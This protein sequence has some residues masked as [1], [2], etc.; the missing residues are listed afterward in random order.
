[1]RS[2]ISQTITLPA[3][4]QELFEMYLDSARHQE[5]TGAPVTIA[6][7]PG[8]EFR[9]FDGVLSGTILVVSSPDLI[10]QSW[11]STAFKADDP[12]ST[13]ILNFVADKAFG[14]IN[15]V[16]LDVPKHDYDGVTQGWEKF[17]WTPWREYLKGRG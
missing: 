4:A 15:L 11:R 10:V 6:K 16:H 8:A 5:I 13:L 7:E 9:A 1:M 3:P 2:V 17:Y 14:R 12:D